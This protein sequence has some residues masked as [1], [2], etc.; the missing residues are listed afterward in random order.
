MKYVIYSVKNNKRSGFFCDVFSEF[1]G[2]KYINVL[3]YWLK[4]DY[5]VLLLYNI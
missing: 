1:D 4:V 2:E 3:I 5:I